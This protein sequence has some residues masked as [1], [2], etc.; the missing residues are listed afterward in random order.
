[1]SI[2]DDL[3]GGVPFLYCPRCG[4]AENAGRDCAFCSHGDGGAEVIAKNLE[5]IFNPPPPPAGS[6]GQP[7][8]PVVKKK[9]KK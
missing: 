3:K 6:L 4:N 9:K 1:L 8:E 5:A 7:E 2:V